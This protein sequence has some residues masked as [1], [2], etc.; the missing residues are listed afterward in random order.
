MTY[1]Q[2]M[3]KHAIA[4][5]QCRHVNGIVAN[6]TSYAERRMVVGLNENMRLQSKGCDQW[7]YENGRRFEIVG[8]SSVVQRCL[9]SI[10]AEIH[11]I[12]TFGHNQLEVDEHTYACRTDRHLHERRS[13]TLSA[14]N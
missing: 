7:T 3:V 6:F 11:L 10:T 8:Q 2:K 12:G 1:F 14:F 13:R 5:V 4:T 9:Q